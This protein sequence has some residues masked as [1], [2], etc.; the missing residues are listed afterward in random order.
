MNLHCGQVPLQFLRSARGCR[1]SQGTWG[2]HQHIELLRGIDAEATCLLVKARA[3]DREGVT[4]RFMTE[5]G[6]LYVL[7]APDPSE[8]PSWESE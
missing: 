2:G 1:L 8:L 6:H 4:V 5:S 3:I 7:S